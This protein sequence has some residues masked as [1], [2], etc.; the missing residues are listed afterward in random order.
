MLES[1]LV[2]LSASGSVLLLARAKAGARRRVS[3]FVLAFASLAPACGRNNAPAREPPLEELDAM[4]T[5]S[6]ITR[7]LRRAGG[8]HYHARTTM[9]ITSSGQGQVGQ[10]GVRDGVTTT[11]DVWMD[12][13]G[14]YRLLETNDKDGGREVVLSGRELAVALRYERMMKRPLQDAEARRFLE[15]GVG[16]PA[17]AWEI[18]R[19]FAEVT[20][21]EE[22]AATGKASVYD[23]KRADEAQAIRGDIESTITPLQ[24]WR[25]TV[26]VEKL[27]GQ[28][29]VD[30][31]TGAPL[32]TTLEASFALAR[33]GVP[34]SGIVRVD[35]E[36]RGLGQ[37]KP[38]EPANAEEL[39][40]RQRTILEEKALLGRVGSGDNA[41][42]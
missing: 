25:E 24:K 37:M 6:A 23:V 22:L 31:R 26:N 27:A 39:P 30:D 19:R 7:A 18:A 5:P 4:L 8:G 14:H 3:T 41:Q 36:I 33:D 12:R 1:A 20:R 2:V 28:V 10:A 11:T 17:M 29:K 35:A 40:T 15:E 16:G 38:I 9:E 21:G 13:F 34:M 42:R 32:R